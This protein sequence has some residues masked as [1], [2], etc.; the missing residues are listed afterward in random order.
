[1]CGI[2]FVKICS[3]GNDGFFR[4]HTG[5]AGNFPLKLKILSPGESSR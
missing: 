1:M 4:H 5:T 3:K 2:K